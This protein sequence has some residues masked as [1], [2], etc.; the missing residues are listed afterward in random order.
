MQR[1]VDPIAVFIREYIDAHGYPP[2]QHKI[3]K[4]CYLTVSAMNRRIV[5]L[6]LAGRIEYTPKQA[7]S[8][9]LPKDSDP[10]PQAA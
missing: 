5:Q 7:R 2:T 4:A 8:V 3:A 6:S 1:A 10:L 9:A